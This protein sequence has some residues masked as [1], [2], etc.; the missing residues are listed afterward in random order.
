[1]NSADTQPQSQRSSSVGDTP[2]GNY[3]SSQPPRGP[4]RGRA[5]GHSLRFEEGQTVR[6]KILGSTQLASSR[7]AMIDN[8]FRLSLVPWRPALG[9]K[10]GREVM[11]LMRRRYFLAIQSHQSTWH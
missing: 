6:G 9:N 11:G 3:A 4:S 10:I 8:G 1:M 2:L 7:F 5:Q